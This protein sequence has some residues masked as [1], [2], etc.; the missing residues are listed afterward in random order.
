MST[1]IT[2]DPAVF[3]VQFPA[4]ASTTKYPDAT[5]QEYFNSATCY[6]SPVD[7]GWLN[8]DCRARALNMMT[9]HLTALSDLIAKGKA[10]G[11]KTGATVDK[12]QVQ[13]MTP[14]LKNQWQW[15]LGLTP[16]GAQLHALLQSVSVGGVYIGGLTERSAFR[17]VGGIY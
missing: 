11:I 8:G 16:Y 10:P 17:K 2:F 14:P 15:W 4:F 13:L 12:V 1:V 6:I 7:Y 3:R 5:L 9:A